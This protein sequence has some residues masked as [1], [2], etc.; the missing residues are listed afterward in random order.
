MRH[1]LFLRPANAGGFG[2][3]RG[4]ER[5]TSTGLCSSRAAA[6]CSSF[7]GGR[8]GRVARTF[9]QSEEAALACWLPHPRCF[10]WAFIWCV[11]VTVGKRGATRC[12]C[13]NRRWQAG[14]A[15]TAFLVWTSLVPLALQ[16]QVTDVSASRS[17]G[18]SWELS[19]LSLPVELCQ[20]FPRPSAWSGSL[21]SRALFSPR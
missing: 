11:G 10:C 2:V 7:L 1:T 4:E 19:L 3:G 8:W 16:W 20:C 6:F 15:R 12:W 21:L 9:L 18:C 13:R 14:D 5:N 17:L